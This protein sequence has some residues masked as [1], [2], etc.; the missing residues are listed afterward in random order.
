MTGEIMVDKR[1]V[2]H[3]ILCELC[4]LCGNRL[5]IHPDVVSSVANNAQY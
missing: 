1:R 2:Y 3:F 4:V 5:N